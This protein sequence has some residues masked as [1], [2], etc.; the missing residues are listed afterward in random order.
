MANADDINLHLLVRDDG[1]GGADFDNGSGLIGQL[2]LSSTAEK[3]T[4][5]SATIPLR[6]N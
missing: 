2:T 5:L 3:G 1:I 4:S 6:G